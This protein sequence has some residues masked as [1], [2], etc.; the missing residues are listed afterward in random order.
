MILVE[1]VVGGGN[2]EGQ[3]DARKETEREAVGVRGQGA[4][5]EAGR[6]QG[7]HDALGA[8]AGRVENL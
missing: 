7:V 3:E 6:G 8:L 5:D 4:G 1:K 2:G